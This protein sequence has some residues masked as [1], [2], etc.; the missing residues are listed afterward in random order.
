MNPKRGQQ[1]HPASGSSRAGQSP[2]SSRALEES[3]T[4]APCGQL[5]S[6]RQRAGDSAELQ[7]PLIVSARVGVTQ[8]TSERGASL[9]A[10]RG[11][12]RFKNTCPYESWE[13]KLLPL[14]YAY[15]FKMVSSSWRIGFFYYCVLTVF[16]YDKYY[17]LNEKSIFCDL[18]EATQQL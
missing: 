13:P 11:G 2:K 8:V 6:C 9:E 15:K 12:T 3:G 14:A 4:A 18:K 1:P 17:F 16:I 7:G 5:A 10:K